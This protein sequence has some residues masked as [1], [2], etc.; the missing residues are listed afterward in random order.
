MYSKLLAKISRLFFKQKHVIRYKMKVIAE[1]SD[2]DVVMYCH[3]Y[4]EENNLIDE[5]KQF[6][7]NIQ[8]EYCVCSY[9]QEYIAAGQCYDMQM[10]ARGY[11]KASALQGDH[12]DKEQLLE[13]CNDCVHSL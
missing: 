8:S 2:S 7:E 1:M 4:C 10:V 12:I 11:I 13:S 5:W 9:L 6:Q 3:R